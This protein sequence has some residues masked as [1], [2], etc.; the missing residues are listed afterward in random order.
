MSVTAVAR[1]TVTDCDPHSFY[2]SL[3]LCGIRCRRTLSLFS[4]STFIQFSGCGYTQVANGHLPVDI[5]SV[6]MAVRVHPFPSRTRQLSSLAP[7]ILGWK[8]PGKIGRR[9]HQRP[10]AF[11]IRSFSL[12]FCVKFY[13]KNGFFVI[14][15][16]KLFHLQ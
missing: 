4:P 15:L 13:I 9:R 2:E 11:R 6:P 3:G 7:K 1:A 5:Q 8:R 16:S 12:L 10:D 14:W